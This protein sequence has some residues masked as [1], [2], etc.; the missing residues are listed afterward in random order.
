[1]RKKSAPDPASQNEH[2]FAEAVRIFREKGYHATSMQNIA[3]AVGL[4]K[5]SLYHY[6]SSKEDLL[7]R[8]FEHSSGAMTRDLE[9]IVTSKDSPTDKL[10][11]A[12]QVHLT[13][14]CEQ[15]DIYAVYLSE[16]RALT[17]RRYAQVRA[18]AEEHARL[19]E[20]IIQQGV[21]TGD[22][23]ATDVKMTTLAILGM[24][25][26]LYQWY[27]PDGRLSPEQIAATFSDTII[28][29]LKRK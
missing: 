23:R 12:I 22:F 26:W 8:I 27:S 13:S 9:T 29:G 3:D 10:R 15:L 25:N 17:N 14:L 21:T 5:G 7:Y 24:C 28:N 6:I 2:I 18:E 20:K 1:M 16:R 4:Q 19:L 11:Q